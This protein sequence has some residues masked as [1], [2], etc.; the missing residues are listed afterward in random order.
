MW[1]VLLVYFPLLMIVSSYWPA[2]DLDLKNMIYTTVSHYRAME[3]FCGYMYTHSHLC[4]EIRCEQAWHR[5]RSHLTKTL[6]E[7]TFTICACVFFFFSSLVIFGGWGWPTSTHWHTC[8]SSQP[9]YSPP[10]QKKGPASLSTLRQIVVDSNVVILGQ[11]E[12][13]LVILCVHKLFT[14]SSLF[15]LFQF[16]IPCRPCTALPT[17]CFSLS[18]SF[19]FL[20]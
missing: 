15:P 1:K 18:P 9:I 16:A 20:W 3:C 17:L 13:S 12:D 6:L 5:S 4:D 7:G 11:R 8:S 14:C 19:V 10:V 2:V